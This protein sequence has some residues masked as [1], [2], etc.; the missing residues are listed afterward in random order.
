[1]RTHT[2]TLAYER[3]NDSKRRGGPS[4]REVERRSVRATAT[5]RTRVYAARAK[6]IFSKQRQQHFDRRVL[7][8][9]TTH[10]TLHAA[11]VFIFYFIFFVFRSSSLFFSL[12]VVVAPHNWFM[13]A[14]FSTFN[15]IPQ[16]SSS[17]D[18]RVSIFICCYTLFFLLA[19]L[20][21][22][23]ARRFRLFRATPARWYLICVR[24]RSESIRGVSDDVR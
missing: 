16:W 13:R 1:M 23:P 5:A 14:H 20:R 7:A 10:S 2:K 22:R 19:H 8:K 24:F 18:G 4:V 9:I 21:S 17:T 11:C 3:L 6:G 12:A 15:E